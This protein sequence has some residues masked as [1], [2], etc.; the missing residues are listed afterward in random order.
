MSSLSDQL[1]K[2]GLVTKDQVKK[3]AEKP[4]FIKKK[5]KNTKK[6]KEEPSDLA[7][8][9]QQRANETNKE[10]QEAARIKQEA[11]RIKKL[12][13]KKINKL[14]TENLLNDEAAEIR[15]NFVVGTTIKYLYV[16]EQQQQDL[17]DGKLAITFLGGKRSII[18]I[19][20][21]HEILKINPDKIVVSIEDK[22]D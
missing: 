11:A 3:A 16:T 13:N 4:K 1:L 12:T 2:A 9:Y 17:A 7:N 20:I 10:K 5:R 15:Y 8:F 22:S 6:S 14:I 18:P 19:D 21:G